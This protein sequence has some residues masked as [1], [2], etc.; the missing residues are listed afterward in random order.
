MSTKAIPQNV[1][2][3]PALPSNPPKRAGSFPT[4]FLTVVAIIILLVVA[5]VL[6]QQ[7]RGLFFLVLS[8]CVVGLSLYAVWRIIDAVFGVTDEARN[9]ADSGAVRARRTLLAEKEV[10]LRVISELKFDYE[11]GRVSKADYDS[12]L[13]Q[14]QRDYAAITRKLEEEQSDLRGK[15]EQE[16]ARRL[17]QEGLAPAPSEEPSR[18]GSKKESSKKKVSK[19]EASVASC[20]SCQKEIDV[21]SVFC[22]HCGHRMSAK[23]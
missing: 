22:K 9:P 3:K 18:A 21:D 4:T 13:P 16:L 23:S 17:S 5:L 15:V 6:D 14:L 20:P 10:A 1:A 19:A 12:L 7:Q 8:A 2:A 11:V